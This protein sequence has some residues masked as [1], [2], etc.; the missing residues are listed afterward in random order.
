MQCRRTKGMMSDGCV[1][2]VTVN[3]LSR[4]SLLNFA[5]LSPDADSE[6][7]PVDDV[8]DESE[9]LAEVDDVDESEELAEVDDA[10]TKNEKS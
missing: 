10:E 5:K 8:D 6:D 4:L 3:Q 7:I 2:G 9:E 1:I